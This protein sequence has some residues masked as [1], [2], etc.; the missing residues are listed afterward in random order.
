MIDVDEFA[1]FAEYFNKYWYTYAL[2]L[3]HG[4]TIGPLQFYLSLSDRE[5]DD[6]VDSINLMMDK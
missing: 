5:R 1:I 6:F 2:K 4:S 3:G